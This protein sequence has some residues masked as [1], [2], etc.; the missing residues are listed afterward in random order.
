MNSLENISTQ[1]VSNDDENKIDDIDKLDEVNNTAEKETESENNKTVSK[2]K[3]I[4]KLW[5]LLFV[6]SF[7]ELITFIGFSWKIFTNFEVGNIIYSI[8][9]VIFYF[10]AIFVPFLVFF[11]FNIFKS[12]IPEIKDF[13]SIPSKNKKIND[14]I[15]SYKTTFINEETGFPNYKTR[16][17]ADLYFNLDTVMG[18]LAPKYPVNKALKLIGSSFI[19]LGILGTFIGF[20]VAMNSL[21]FGSP[22]EM[23]EGIKQLVENGLNTAF[24]TSIVGVMC[25][26]FYNFL[27]FNPLIHETNQYFEKLC[28]D[29]D[30]EY[31]ISETEALMQYTMTT[32]EEGDSIPF[33]DSLNLIL[34]NMR[35]QTIALKDFNDELSIKLSNITQ[36]VN[37]SMK[38]FFGE[39][40]KAQV[41][42][43][44]HSNLEEL[45][46]AL[47]T[48]STQLN[49]ASD[50]VAETVNKIDNEVANSIESFND[51]LVSAL[52]NCKD[53]ASHIETVPEKMSGITS[54]LEDAGDKLSSVSDTVSINMES[55]KDNFETLFNDIQ[56]TQ[57]SVSEILSKVQVNE[58]YSG[59]NLEGLTH[60]T[61]EILNGFRKVDVSL[62]NIFEKISEEIANYNTTVSGTLSDYLT[63]FADAS[64]NFS[65]TIHGTVDDFNN[66]M[67]NVNNTLKSIENNSDKFDVSIKHLEKSLSKSDK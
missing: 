13:L 26:L 3:P 51:A 66:S 52:E 16:A 50:S 5:F 17:N 15:N 6:G 54:A 46:T 9:S 40:I 48:A 21:S 35:D 47:V 25:S 4:A 31:Y 61:N 56:N 23:L 42:E 19:G 43:S 14:L 63:Q 59:R 2:K 62:S 20:S 28:D 34:S 53:A 29:L 36:S 1:N 65:S 58:E 22:E 37:S 10:V 18:S 49:E 64:K 41:V 44:I 27:I 39:D 11:R 8:L 30:Q 12:N 33:S 7:L 67:L 55:V 60:E 57:N 32:T 38:D 45:E 24:N